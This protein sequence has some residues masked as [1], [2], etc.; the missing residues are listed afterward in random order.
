[1]RRARSIP[2]HNF[3]RGLIAGTAIIVGLLVANLAYC[4]LWRD[5]G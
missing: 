4:V 1:L 3:P 2:Q 5:R